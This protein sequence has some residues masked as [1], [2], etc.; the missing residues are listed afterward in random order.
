MEG[1]REGG[2]QRGR[3]REER[4]RREVGGIGSKKQPE[5]WPSRIQTND[6]LFMY[7]DLHPYVTAFASG[8]F[9]RSFCQEGGLLMNG[10]RALV[11]KA[12]GLSSFLVLWHMRGQQNCAH[13][14][15]RRRTPTPS[16]T[17]Q[18]WHTDDL[19]LSNLQNCGKTNVYSV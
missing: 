18:Y 12:R 1:V 13:L 6:K 11:E 19:T 9:G 16:R 8:S 5:R 3:E 14:W 7:L 10:I 2:R 4:D 15:R 17:Q